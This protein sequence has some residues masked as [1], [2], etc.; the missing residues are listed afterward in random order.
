LFKALNKTV[1]I[2]EYTPVQIVDLMTNNLDIGDCLLNCSN[3]GLCEIQMVYVMGEGQMSIGCKC[4]EHFEGSACDYDMRICA[5]NP[6]LN[7]ATCV[8]IISNTTYDFECQCGS[9]SF[10][11]YCE[12]QID[13]CENETCS[14]NGRCVDMN[15]QP[16]C[17]CFKSYSGEHCQIESSTIKAIKATRLTT[18]LL[19]IL[20]IVSFYLLFIL[21]DLC[22][23]YHK[24]HQV[25]S[26]AIKKGQTAHF[27]SFQYKNFE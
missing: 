26:S 6:C 3:N 23:W 9:F 22:N 8:D 17:E 11:L 4:N 18:S 19:A 15:K 20:I 25:D 1:S 14:L 21:L 5:S 7:N 10:G 2:T 27:T 12:N 16:V 13:V 24:R